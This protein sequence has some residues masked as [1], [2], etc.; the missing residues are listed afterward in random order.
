MD[1]CSPRPVAADQNPPIRVLLAAPHAAALAGLRMSLGREHFDV[2]AEAAD[3]TAAVAAALREQPDICVLDADIPGGATQA[4]ATITGELP[5]TAVVLLA[6]PR[7]DE[8]MLDA[9]RAGAAGYLFS[10]MD[11]ERLRFALRGVMEGEAAL[12]RKLVSRL[13]EEFRTRERGR[14]LPAALGTDVELTGREWDVLEGLSR[15]ASTRDVAGN[16][17][18]SE[19]TVRR[20]VS[21]AIAKLG[22][23]DRKSAVA[24]LR[25]A[26]SR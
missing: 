25:A 13:M 26:R 21:T 19:V 11:P 23:P 14:R 6:P 10:D 22:V 16:L 3:A 5:R 24:A 9:G 15:G 8:P 7:G 2:V 12:P 1:V 17:G 4:T 20:H 18:I